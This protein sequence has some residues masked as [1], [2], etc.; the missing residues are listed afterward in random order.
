MSGQYNIVR[1][2]SFVRQGSSSCITDV[3]TLQ[4]VRSFFSLQQK[5]GDALRLELVGPWIK[6]EDTVNKT[7]Y[8]YNQETQCGQPDPPD[9]IIKYQSSVSMSASQYN[10]NSKV[11]AHF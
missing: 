1:K 2:S 3:E 10:F 11:N 7:S 8:W 6:F 4:K 9:D 5:D